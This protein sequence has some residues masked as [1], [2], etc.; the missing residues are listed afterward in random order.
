MKISFAQTFLLIAFAILG[1][2]AGETQKLRGAN[3]E[4]VASKIDLANER[5]LENRD[6]QIDNLD[7]DLDVG[8]DFAIDNLDIQFSFLGGLIDL[9]LNLTSFFGRNFGINF[10]IGVDN[11]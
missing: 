8:F 4:A 1:L 10:G 11:F 9:I 6:L 3:V 2:A 7:T 5:G